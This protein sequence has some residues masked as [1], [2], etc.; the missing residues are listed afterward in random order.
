[1]R[2]AVLEQ[3]DVQVVETTW[4]LFTLPITRT[5][6]NKVTITCDADVPVFCVPG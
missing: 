5:P 1:V 3:A 4:L 2:G 6:V